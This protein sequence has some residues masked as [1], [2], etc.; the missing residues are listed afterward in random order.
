MGRVATV[1]TAAVDNPVQARTWTRRG[2]IGTVKAG[3]QLGAT[4]IGY[5][6]T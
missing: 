6:A 1:P 2:A 5:K 3:D 4:R